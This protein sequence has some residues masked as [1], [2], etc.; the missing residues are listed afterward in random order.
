[1]DRIG[2]HQSPPGRPAS[3][4][5][6]TGKGKRDRWVSQRVSQWMATIPGHFLAF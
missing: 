4:A 5:E 2:R 1:V 3:V 6:G